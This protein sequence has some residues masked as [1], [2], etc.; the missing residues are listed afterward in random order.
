[1]HL[2]RSSSCQ[3]PSTSARALPLRQRAKHLQLS[4]SVAPL[5]IL[6][7]L[8]TGWC[9]WGCERTTLGDGLPDKTDCSSCHGRPADPAPP[10]ALNGASSTTDLG[11]G[12]H[13]AHLV[14][15]KVSGPVACTECHTVPT[16]VLNHPDPLGRPAPVT[17]GPRASL[18]GAAPTWNRNA[19]ACSNTYCHGSTLPESSS[20]KAPVWTKVDGSQRSCTACHGNPPGGSHPANG[21]C[22]L[23]HGAVV[24]AGGVIKSLSL[25]VNGKVDFGD[26]GVHPARYTDP[27]LH[28]ADTNLGKL[29]CRPCHGQKLEGTTVAL[30]CDTCHRTGWRT[31]CTFC[32]GGTLET[33]GAPP[34]DLLGG[35]A[36]TALG[37]GSHRE[38]VS[39]TTHPA[40]ACTQCHAEVTDV[41]TPGH[42][43]DSTPGKSE[44]IFTKGLSPAGQYAAP[45]CATLYCHGTGQANGSVTT[46]IPAATPSC[47]SCH[48]SNTQSSTHSFHTSFTCSI[49]HASVVTGSTTIKDPTLHVNGSVDVSLA[50]GTW[51]RTTATCSG[52]AC[53]TSGDITW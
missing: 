50:S 4:A 34:R 35:T 52:S 23:C 15:G 5:G 25:H 28:G 48:P 39:K 21:K 37:V 41:L 22:E 36:T 2:H 46:F 19:A 30:G 42:L 9:G 1:M 7:I 51:T 20:R 18:S 27:S 31:N 49:C 40:Y 45:G 17:F 29:D 13:Q 8:M 33:S 47:Q 26:A 24:S 14:A 38:H 11:V 3:S 43:F 16:D 53:H 32:H 6:F 44:V 12:A 10:V